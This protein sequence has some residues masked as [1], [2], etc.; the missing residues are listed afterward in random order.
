MSRRT[1]DVEDMVGGIACTTKRHNAL[2]QKI[3]TKQ[4]HNIDALKVTI[5]RFTKRR[6]KIF[7][8]ACAENRR[9]IV[10]WVCECKGSQIDIGHLRT[11]QAEADT[12]ILL[13]AVD[14]TFR[15][16]SDISIHS[17]ILTSLF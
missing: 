13:H 8:K 17:P 15:G 14:S 2:S 5:C 16:A 10:A 7:D 4:E 3:L 12:K 6:G 1:V 11:N 9:V